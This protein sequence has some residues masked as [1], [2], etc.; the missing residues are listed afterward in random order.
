MF[1]DSELR[2]IIAVIKGWP[3]EVIDSESLNKILSSLDGLAAKRCE[4]WDETERL[5]LALIWASYSFRPSQSEFCR[6]C[7]K[8]AASSLPSLP[9]PSLLQYLL[10]VS[11]RADDKEIV[12]ESLQAGGALEEVAAT[13]ETNF[14]QLTETEVMKS[15]SW[16][17]TAC[18]PVCIS[19]QIKAELVILFLAGGRCLLSSQS[20]EQR[21]GQG[22]WRKNT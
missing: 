10:L 9:L 8:L 12:L 16:I 6:A 1:T 22:A 5:Q 13:I 18:S 21:P 20:L 15:L 7:L 14:H 11:Y 17:S 4:T 2:H 3:R 19:A